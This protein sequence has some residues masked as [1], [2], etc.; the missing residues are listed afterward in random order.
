MRLL[1]LLLLFACAPAWS[2]EAWC[3]AHPSNCVMSET[4][5]DT[6][7]TR[8]TY[9]DNAALFVSGSSKKGLCNQPFN[10]TCSISSHYG[11]GNTFD[12]DFSISTDSSILNLLPNRN[13]SSV[14]RFLRSTEGFGG[15]IRFGY[16]PIPLGSTVKRI[17][18]RW[19]SY[20][21]STYDF[22]N[23]ASCGNGKIGHANNGSAWAASPLL[24]L[25]TQQSETHVYSLLGPGYN[26][27]WPGHTSFDGFHSG[28]GPHPGAEANLNDWKGKWFRHEMVIRRPRVADS[29]PPGNLGTDFQF[30]TKNV[31]DDLPE[32]EDTRLSSGCTG[33]IWS[34]GVPSQTFNWTTGFYGNADMSSLHT[35]LYRSGTC[36]GWQGWI[37]AAS[38]KWDTDNDTDRIGAAS[39][40]EGGGGGPHAPTNFRVIGKLP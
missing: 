10:G 18:L 24:T 39:E 33:C 20:H 17:A 29:G 16:S 27:V 22:A 14:A 19:Y 23:Q 15:A 21:S 1:V 40:V 2:Q 5:Q 3:N 34:E 9:D 25:E 30:F 37:Y 6:S 26:W 4:F 36:R 7:Y 35:E 31:T 8:T 32:I 28:T 12:S 11:H 13:P 38:A